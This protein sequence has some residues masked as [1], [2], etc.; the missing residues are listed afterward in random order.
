M[1][2]VRLIEKKRDGAHF[3][4]G[5]LDFLISGYVEGRIPDYQIAAWLMAIYHNGMSSTETAGLTRLMRDSGRTLDFSTISGFKVDKHS[6]GGVGD[7]VSL[8]LAPLLASEGLIVPMI[9]GRALAHTGG[10][11]DKLEAIPGFRTDLTL[12]EIDRQLEKI[13]F[14]MV[15]QTEDLCPADKKIY[16][17]RDATG[18][19]PSIPLICASILSKKLAEGLDALVIDVK[20]GSGAIFKDHETAHELATQLVATAQQFNL[21][22]AAIVSNMDRPLGRAVGNWLETRE[23]I[24]VLKGGGPPA[25][26]ELTLVLSAQ[27]LVL[28]GTTGSLDDAMS[29]LQKRLINGDAYD[30]FLQMVEKQGGDLQAIEHPGK[31]HIPACELEITSP[32]AGYVNG[33]HARQIGEI[34]MALGAGRAKVSDAVEYGSGILLHK[35]IGDYVEAGEALCTAFSNE[36]KLLQRYSENLLRAFSIGEEQVQK[37]PLIHSRI[38]AAGEQLWSNKQS[39][40]V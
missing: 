26:V 5:E 2:P 32:T 6:T 39:D 16:A 14:V 29:R 13:G 34:S 38:D 31:Y 17:L 8:P 15:G 22:T 10:T 7:K 18:T 3:T 12:D 35:D 21:N 36:A 11:L 1:N 9:S 28:T 40:F 27:L 24:E 30:K 23:A 25:V 37:Q 20:S 4:D 33:I 19:V